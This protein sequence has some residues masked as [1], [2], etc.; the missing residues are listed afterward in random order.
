MLKFGWFV[1]S[2]SPKVIGN[3][4]IRYDTN[5]FLYDANRN[6]ASLVPFSSYSE[7]VTCRKSPINLLYLPI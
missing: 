2:G 3:I 5:D 7:L 1:G 4:T 6:Y